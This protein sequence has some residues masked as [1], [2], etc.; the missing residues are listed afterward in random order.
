MDAK[1]I[2]RRLVTPSLLGAKPGFVSLLLHVCLL[3]SHPFVDPLALL[4][5][6]CFQLLGLVIVQVQSLPRA[7]LVS[8]PLSSSVEG[9][10]QRSQTADQPGGCLPLGK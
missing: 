2:F 8:G 5:N 1:K 4:T 9:M 6:D 3:H 7:A 10:W